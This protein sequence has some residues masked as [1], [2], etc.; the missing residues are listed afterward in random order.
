ML[1]HDGEDAWRK[2]HVEQPICLFPA[3][4]EVLHVLV[5]LSEGFVSVVLA[6]DIGADRAEV[7]QLLL[8]LLGR[9]L[10]VRPDPAQV[11]IV[12]HLSPS[13]ADDLNV[14]GQELVPVLLRGAR[15][16]R[17]ARLRPRTIDRLTRPNKAGNYELV[18]RQTPSA[19]EIDIPSSF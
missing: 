3:L 11:L 4:L 14:I 19:A 2:G 6:R 9:C 10:D 12:V 13:I 8:Y 15:G 17:V 16:Q 18:S 1:G 5:E 7:V